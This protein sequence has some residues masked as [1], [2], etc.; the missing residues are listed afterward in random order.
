M[1]L[2]K[3]KPKYISLS[4][5]ND[6]ND[7]SSLI[8]AIIEENYGYEII[9]KANAYVCAVERMEISLN[10]IPF[11]KGIKNQHNATEAHPEG[12]G[13]LESITF[14]NRNHLA[15]RYTINFFTVGEIEAGGTQVNFYSL[16]SILDRLS[17]LQFDI[18]D[19][20]GNNTGVEYTCRFRIDEKGYISYTSNPV[21]VVN[22]HGLE[23][24]VFNGHGQTYSG[25]NLDQQIEFP[26]YLNMILG[27]GELQGVNESTI[28]SDFARFDL[29]DELAHVLLA[30][31]LPVIS[32]SV[33]QQLAQ[34]LTDFAPT[35]SY[36]GS[37]TLNGNDLVASGVT[38]NSRQKLIY[39]PAEKR[40]LDLTSPFNIRYI[41]IQAFYITNYS[42][43]LV[44]QL[45]IGGMFQVKLGFY[46]K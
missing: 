15:V 29:G 38:L 45:P 27:L 6:N 5:V 9:D 1:S 40:Y 39:V 18:I 22:N 16:K 21:E 31:S 36:G 33:G 17:T 13:G 12:T 43:N 34:V 28:I 23:L 8:D 3:I 2:G 7:S 32:D 19:A 37:Y 26:K 24:V 20:N 25:N 11:Y 10:G 14:Y 35:S 42:D 44:V 4:M 41:R 30:T 46:S